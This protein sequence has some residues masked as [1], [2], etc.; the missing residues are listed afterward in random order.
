[1]TVPASRHRA[2]RPLYLW[3][4]ALAIAVVFAG[5][6]RSFYLKAVFD[7]SPMTALVAIHGMVMTCW[8]LLFFVEAWLAGSGRIAA[9]R[10][11]GAFGTLLAATVLVLGIATAIAAGHLGRIP[12]GAP[13]PPIFL[14]VPLGDMF[15]FACLTGAGLY[16]RKRSDWHKR[17]MLL[18]CVGLLTAAISRIPVDAWRQAG[19]A[20]YFL[21]T[22][23]LVLACIAWDTLRSRRLHPAFVSGGL[24]VLLSWPLRLALAQTEAW[25]RFAHWLID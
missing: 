8:F 16:L 25:Q 19:I 23:A 10:R 17:L 4:A 22:C 7:P 11:L 20:A 21:S 6:A 3:A 14:V 13:P 1:M 24:L 9:H 5:F 2:E 12:P 15:V 18:S